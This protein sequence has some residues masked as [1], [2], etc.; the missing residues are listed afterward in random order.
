MK[1]DSLST[2]DSYITNQQLP[3]VYK[4]WIRAYLSPLAQQVSNWHQQQGSSL[5]L[6][7]NGAQGTGKSTLS[8]F[9]KLLLKEQYNKRCAILSIDDL[10]LS[11]SERRKLAT[12][13]HPLLQT[14][15]VPGTHNIE[16]GLQTLSALTSNT[17]SSI[18]LPRFNKAC[19]DLY[20]ESEWPVQTGPFD[21]ILFEGWCV[22]AKPQQEAA[23]LA[24]I[25]NLEKNEDIDGTWRR[26]VNQTLAEKYPALFAFIDKLVMLKAPNMEAIVEWRSIQ[27]EKLLK[28]SNGHSTAIMNQTQ[29]QRFIQHYER[30]TQH[31]LVEIP[32]RA[33]V[34]FHLGLDH[35]ITS[36]N[37]IYALTQQGHG[38]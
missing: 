32:K 31:M 18:V 9:L 22:G 6:G 24:P 14:R 19:D 37:G 5:I 1:L 10:Y 23:L 13:K 33:D 30:L 20:P 12:D 17:S 2:I 11:H 27:E 29:L 36:T 3:A 21:I 15:G 35:T 25:N 34:I 8:L 4:E 16:L 7:I 28:S 38:E 26:Y